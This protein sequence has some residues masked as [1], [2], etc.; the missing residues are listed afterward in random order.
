MAFRRKLSPPQDPVGFRRGLE[1]TNLLVTVLVAGSAAHATEGA[2]QPWPVKEF[3]VVSARPWQSWQPFE[4]WLNLLREQVGQE[5]DEPMRGNEILN[6]QLKED[7]EAYLSR[8]AHQLE[9]WGFPPPKLEPVVTRPDGRRAF[10]VFYTDPQ[11]DEQWAGKYILDNSRHISPIELQGTRTVMYLSGMRGALSQASGSSGARLTDVGKATLGHELFHA[12]QFAMP[13]FATG[14][15]SKGDWIT[16]GTAR[17]VGYDLLQVIEGRVRSTS[18]ARRWGQ[19]RY[20]DSLPRYRQSGQSIAPS[21]TYNTS[22]FWRYLAELHARPRQGKPGPAAQAVDHGYLAG[23]FSRRLEGS[24]MADELRWLDEGLRLEQRIGAKGLNRIYPDFV[25][26]YAAYGEHRA[27]SSQKWRSSSFGSCTYFRISP[28]QLERGTLLKLQPVAARC[29]EVDARA[30]SEP[31]TFTVQVQAATEVLA[32]QTVLGTAGGQRVS[33]DPMLAK[34]PFPPAEER[35]WVA[36]TVFLSTPGEL[37]SL[38]LANVAEEARNTETQDVFV[39]VSTSGYVTNLDGPAPPAESPAEPVDP[40]P[41]P[42]GARQAASRDMRTAVKRTVQ[43]GVTIVSLD[44]Q[45]D[46]VRGCREKYRRLN[47]CGPQLVV[48]M[49]RQAASSDI[50]SATLDAGGFFGQAM[51]GAGAMLDNLPEVIDS[52]R[53][54]MREKEYTEAGTIQLSMPYVDYGFTGRLTNVRMSVTR[55]GGGEYVAVGPRDMEPGRMTLFPPSAEVT[56]E[57]YTATFMAGTFSAQLIDP[58]SLPGG[59]LPLASQESRPTLPVARRIEGRFFL[60]AP[61]RDDERT[62]GLFVGDPEGSLMIDVSELLS[63]GPDGWAIDFG[64]FSPPTAPPTRPPAGAPGAGSGGGLMHGCDCSCEAYARMEAEL[65]AMAQAAE[66]G[67][68]PA[69]SF[70]ELARCAMYCPREWANCE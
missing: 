6:L 26:T 32:A 8:A 27:R 2:R 21:D 5:L 41:G 54:A 62:E 48:T 66:Q 61:W 9:A 10:R 33:H 30:F 11:A 64:D 12:V 39:R 46:A 69:P 16:E 35:P 51:A 53:R 25:S 68:V 56:I 52:A 4:R 17:A 24:G 40:S 20:T 50:M 42:S 18:A 57:E 23:L 13:F 15:T 22:S 43:T 65:D 45:P 55:E 38:I 49:R 47:F 3:E 60:T 63:T 36:T 7:M 58:Q 59:T 29:I 14:S 31:V 37:Q 28:D 1:M 44:R 70:Q 19:R 67:R 34:P